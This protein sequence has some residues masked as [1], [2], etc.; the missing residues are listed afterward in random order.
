M[1]RPPFL[2]HIEQN[3]PR[4]S[5]G[6]KKI[7]DFILREYDKAAFMTAA[8][9]GV[10]VGVSESTVVRFAAENGYDGYPDLQ[11]YL[12]DMIRSRLTSIQR[13]HVSDVRLS[14]DKIL[15]NAMGA[16]A[17]MIRRTLEQTSREAFRGAVEAING[18]EHIYI[19]G[20]RSS[21]ALANF[22]AL[23]LNILHPGVV[24][25]DAFSASQIYEQLL[26]IN[27]NDVCIAISF[28]RYSKR[29]ITALR[30]A[31]DRGA[32]A[33]AITDC[34]RSPIAELAQLVL[35]AHCDAVAFVDSLVAPLSLINALLAACARSQGDK[36]Y[37][38]L[39]SLE[40][41]WTQYEIYDS[42]ELAEAEDAQ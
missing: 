4:L 11:R 12:Q 24:Y 32:T 18:A 7:A 3:Y 35:T 36:V 15:E 38:T 13:M 2:N 40:Q 1:S 25:V 17:E 34:Q 9:L 33:V 30:F 26:R 21:A 5:K 19:Q 41:V 23:Y 16:D 37:E 14:D 22:L 20:T 6:H 28:P 39:H 27:K 29:T 8:A 42:S 31:R 10:A